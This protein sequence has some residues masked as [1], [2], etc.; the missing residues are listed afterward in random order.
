MFKWLPVVFQ[1]GPN[2]IKRSTRKPVAVAFAKIELADQ[3]RHLKPGSGWLEQVE[4]D[5]EPR[6]DDETL[7]PNAEFRQWYDYIAE[8]TQRGGR[9][10]AYQHNTKELLRAAGFIDI[11]EAVIRAP[12]NG[13]STDP[14]QKQIGRWYNIGLAEGLEAISAAPLTRIN[15]WSFE[16][17]V[18]PLCGRVSKELANSKIHAYNNM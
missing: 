12:V 18:K 3:T 1:A 13:W 9:P 11:V 4:I 5:L 17:H 16:Q 10:I 15:R 6:C 8:A 7:P 14:H 2:S